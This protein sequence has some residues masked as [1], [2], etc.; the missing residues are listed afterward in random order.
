MVQAVSL[1]SLAPTPS[2][3]TSMSSPAPFPRPEPSVLIGIF[4]AAV[5]HVRP[6]DN[7]DDGSLTAAYEKAVRLAEERSR[8]GPSGWTSEME[9]VK[10]EDEDIASP[11]RSDGPV[12]DIASSG[13]RQSLPHTNGI[14]RANRPKS[15]VLEKGM[16]GREED[17]E[18]PPLPR[19]TAGDS[20]L[21]GQQWP[22]VDEIAGAIREW[23][24]VSNLSRSDPFSPN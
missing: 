23:Y 4:P 1:S 20:T 17:K 21:A 10:E 24:G 6:G 3:S 11:A 16:V 2:A 14:S 9:A 19:L 12:I 18:Q 8:I 13:K 5:A 22:L 7:V 15:L